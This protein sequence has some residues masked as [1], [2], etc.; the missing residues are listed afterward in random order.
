MMPPRF[1]Y[2]GS[3][4]KQLRGVYLFLIFQVMIQGQSEKVFGKFG[5]ESCIE[6]RALF[7]G[8]NV[9]EG[10]GTDTG[11]QFVLQRDES[12]HLASL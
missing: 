6:R 1:A 3:D 9:V 11:V 8:H 5:A 2:I 4:D 7:L 10:I 12:L